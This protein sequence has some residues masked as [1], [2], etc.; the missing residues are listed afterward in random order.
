M[1]DAWSP[2][3]TQGEPETQAGPEPGR[4]PRLSGGVE[5]A[6]YAL[7]SLSLLL[8]LAAIETVA[9]APGAPAGGYGFDCVVVVACSWRCRHRRSHW[10]LC[11]PAS[12]EKRSDRSGAI[13]G[14]T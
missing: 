8:V 2:P 10:P 5:C 14:W 9:A 11:S 3:A 12:S 1:A 4:K 7:L 13:P 6:Y